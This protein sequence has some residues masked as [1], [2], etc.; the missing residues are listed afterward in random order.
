MATQHGQQILIRVERFAFFTP[1][2]KKKTDATYIY[3]T[4]GKKLYKLEVQRKK[5]K[6]GRWNLV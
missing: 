5:F 1:T 3:V 2:K 4:C 6:P